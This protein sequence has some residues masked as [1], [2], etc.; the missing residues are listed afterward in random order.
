MTDL[1]SDYEKIVLNYYHQSKFTRYVSLTLFFT[2]FHKLINGK[3]HA[4]ANVCSL[5]KKQGHK[6]QTQACLISNKNV[7][8][9]HCYLYNGKIF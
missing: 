7:K 2:E 5:M 9:Q 1:I 6:M 8:A 3:C 4:N